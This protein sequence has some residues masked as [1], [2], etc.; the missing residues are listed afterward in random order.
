[1]G[2]PKL[3]VKAAS[4]IYGN[5]TNGLVALDNI[6][7]NVEDGEFISLVGPSG[8]GKTTLLWSIAGLHDLTEGVIQLDSEA[9]DGPHP[10]RLA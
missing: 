1:M 9:I 5:K 3:V 10:Q 8:C 2:N 6:N 7:L 4:K